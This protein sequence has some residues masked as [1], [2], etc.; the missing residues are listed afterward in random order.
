M[1]TRGRRAGGDAGT[2]LM[3]RGTKRLLRIAVSLGLL[4]FLVYEIGPT[5][6]VDAFGRARPLYLIAAFLVICADCLLRAYNWMRVLNARGDPVSYPTV[7]RAF[8]VGGFFGSF[9]PS[10]LGADAGRTVALTGSHPDLSI[11]RSASSIVMLN[12]AGLW[13]LGTVF[14][15]GLGG[16]AVL[17][18]LPSPVVTLALIAGAASVTVPALLWTSRTVPD[19]WSEN[20]ILDRVATFADALGRYRDVRGRL[21]PVFLIGLVNQGL[22]VLTFYLVFR[23]G[24]VQVHPLY[25]P[26]LVPAVTL[27]R[28]VPA[29]IAGFGAE[30][31]AVVVAFGWAGV[32]AP[33]AMAA[34]LLAS[35][36]SGIF[37]AGCG[38]YFAGENVRA[39]LR[40]SVE[41]RRELTRRGRTGRDGET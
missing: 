28:L 24:G 14:V 13:A 3:E 15:G 22:S 21:V 39:L 30:Q 31:A 36:L 4:A 25:F 17:A 18:D 19:S 6:L 9:V 41:R 33:R 38:L 37:I 23:A 10:S 12:L 16:L 5:R 32:A 40:D 7:F 27:A 26:V 8:A 1:R 29:S 35:L 34:S 2:R 20:P 11:A